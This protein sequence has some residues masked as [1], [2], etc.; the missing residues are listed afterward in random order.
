MLEGS[1]A[2]HEEEQFVFDD[3]ATNVA[4]VLAS[5]KLR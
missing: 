5:L 2:I 1:F 3:R 4:A